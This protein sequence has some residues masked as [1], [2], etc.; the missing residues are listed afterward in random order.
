MH[1]EEGGLFLQRLVSPL[2]WL[3]VEFFS[4]AGNRRKR[5]NFR[6]TEMGNA[7]C[8]LCGCVDQASIGIVERWGR[9]EKLAEPGLHF[10]NPLAGQCLAGILSTRINSLDV[11]IETKTKVTF[12]VLFLNCSIKLLN[13]ILG[14][15]KKLINEEL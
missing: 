10:F 11:R 12:A 2:N 5:E 4:F 9:F 3:L 8:L 13:R 15:F 7:W 1:G 14:F 6:S